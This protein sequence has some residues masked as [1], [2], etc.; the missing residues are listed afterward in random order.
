MI[1]TAVGAACP[2]MFAAAAVVM[3][4]LI[5]RNNRSTQ[6]PEQPQPDHVT[7]KYGTVTRVPAETHADNPAALDQWILTAPEWHP[8]WD[9]YVIGLISLA[10]LPNT[11]PPF[12]QRP[13]VTHELVVFALNP[14]HGPHE[15]A[16]FNSR[17]LAEAVLTPVNVVEQF[18]CTDDQARDLVRLC[19]TA[20]V[21]GVLT[22][23]TGDAPDRYRAA[24]R[25]SIH[26]T[27]NH[28]LDPH[29][30]RAN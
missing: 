18:T 9:Q 29:H 13:G 15:A 19:A 16:T 23:E 21:N 12:R 8:I 3:P 14:E 1:A 5:H 6:M 11:P 28:L 20:C 22:P 10:D 17:S 24:W 7:G 25:Q 30:G 2:L 27:L 26:Q 4:V